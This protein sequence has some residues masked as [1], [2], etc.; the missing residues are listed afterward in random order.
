M[1]QAHLT[2]NRPVETS[3]ELLTAMQRLMVQLT[4]APP[5]DKNVLVE[6][7]SSGCNQSLP[8]PRG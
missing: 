8:C 1:S 5:P 4:A 6:M 3:E 7:L 2:S